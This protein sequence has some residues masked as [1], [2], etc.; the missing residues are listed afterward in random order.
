MGTVLP[1]D[2]FP[3]DGFPPDGFPPDEFSPDDVARLRIAVT[4]IARLLNRE[5]SEDGLTRTQLSVLG[6][7]V[8]DGPLGLGEL[9][10]FEGINPT[11]LSRIVAKL[12]GEGL[13]ERI[14]DPCDRRAARVQA[15]SSGVRTH[16]RGRAR[17]TR[18]LEAHLSA[19]RPDDGAR[20]LAALPALE[21]LADQVGPRSARTPT[22]AGTL[23]SKSPAT[24]T[25]HG[26]EQH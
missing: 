19:L 16:R 14:A 23:S 7:V 5:S 12:D 2:G 17:R 6:T 20:L 18:L 26:G 4:R 24:P 3:P 25:P 22:T 15:T 11:M 1:P 8:R 21:A 9:A 13:I 10:E